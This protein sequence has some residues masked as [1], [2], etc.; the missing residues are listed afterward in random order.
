M[1][2]VRGGHCARGDRHLD[3]PETAIF[4]EGDPIAWSFVGAGWA[5][6]ECTRDEEEPEEFARTGSATR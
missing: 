2:A 4:D 1:R 3:I 6:L 5:H